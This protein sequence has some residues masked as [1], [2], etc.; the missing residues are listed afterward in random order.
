M[1]FKVITAKVMTVNKIAKIICFKGPGAMVPFERLLEKGP[2]PYSIKYTVAF[3]FC[4]CYPESQMV[5]LFFFRSL[6][7]CVDRLRRRT[8]GITAT[9][10]PP[11]EPQVFIWEGQAKA[12][13]RGVE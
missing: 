2:R 11:Q 1:R 7:R 10:W 4:Y 9:N 6:V 12:G 13:S 8:V 5:F 3:R